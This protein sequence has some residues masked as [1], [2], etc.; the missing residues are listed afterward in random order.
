MTF[1]C[2]ACDS[3]NAISFRLMRISPSYIRMAVASVTAIGVW[4]AALPA[5]AGFV[6]AQKSEQA[7]FFESKV[8]PVLSERCFSCHGDKDQKGGLRLDSRAAVLKGR[9][10]GNEVVIN[11]D[12]ENSRLVKAISYDVQF[13][14]PP[15]GKL[16]PD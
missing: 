5:A 12:T 14:M 16:R 11:G 8:R 4:V 3:E 9:G 2:A 15:A 7:A 1:L 13:R 10:A 6:A